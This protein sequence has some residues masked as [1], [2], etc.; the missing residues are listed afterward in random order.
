[1]LTLSDRS[2]V[3][4]SRAAA[5]AVIGACWLYNDECNAALAEFWE[6]LRWQA[7]FRHDSWEPM[8]SSVSFLFYIITWAMLERYRVFE[9]WQ[10]QKGSQDVAWSDVW[11]RLYFEGM[12]Y[13]VPLIAFDTAFPRRAPKLDVPAPTLGL[14]ALQVF[15]SITLYD[16]FFFFGH[17]ALHSRPGVYKALHSRHHMHSSVR[18]CETIRHNIADGTFDVMCSIAALNLIGSHPISRSLHNV[19]IIGLLCELHAGYDLPWG[20]HNLVPFQILGGPPRH[21]YHHKHGR[22]YQQKFFTF[23]DKAFGNEP[24]LEKAPKRLI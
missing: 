16:V 23:L 3:H 24:P 4:A 11:E 2:L 13:I 14:V 6:W 1:M 12:W 10:I 8:L 9:R 18:A 7:W 22:Y 5:A 20:L 21:D 15:L 19:V 17:S